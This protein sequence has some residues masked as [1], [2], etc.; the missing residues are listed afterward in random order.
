MGSGAGSS[1]EDGGIGKYLERQ[2]DTIENVKGRIPAWYLLDEAQHLLA[3][4]EQDHQIR[5]D[6]GDVGPEIALE[7]P[8]LNRQWLHRWRLFYRVTWRTVNLRIKCS[9]ETLLRRMLAF[10]SNILRLRWLHKHLGARAE[11]LWLDCDQ[12]PMWFTASANSKTLSPPVRLGVT[13]KENFPATRERF[14]VMTRT[15]YPRLP[16]DGKTIAVMFR[17]GEGDGREIRRKLR[18]PPGVLLQFAPKGSYRLEHTLEYYDW[19][20][21]EHA[22]AADGEPHFVCIADWF[23]PNLDASFRTCVERHGG[24]LVHIPGS[25]TGHVQVNDTRLH[26]PYSAYYIRAETLEAQEQLRASKR[27][28]SVTRQTVLNRAAQCW[29]HVDHAKVSQGFLAAGISIALDGSEDHLLGQ[30]VVEL[31]NTLDMP[32]V[33]ARI[34]VEV[35]G[36]VAAGRLRSLAQCKEVMVPHEEHRAEEE[37]EEARVWQ[38]LEERGAEDEEADSRLDHTTRACWCARARACAHECGTVFVRSVRRPALTRRTMPTL[39]RRSPSLSLCRGRKATGHRR[40]KRSQFSMDRSSATEFRQVLVQWQSLCKGTQPP[41][42]ARCSKQAPFR[43]PWAQ[44]ASTGRV[45]GSK[46]YWSRS[47]ARRRV[48]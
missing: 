26:A 27:L 35:A 14:T 16:A 5:I 22:V 40:W 36:E 24:M 33:R 13:V 41:P 23:K 28:P 4:M 29:S 3:E 48:W 20:L 32:S 19:I 34:G 6:S 45:A 30:E 46:E 15:A 38:A 31:W 7:K 47:C 37:G 25:L 8:V 44:C 42:S 1:E 43:R 12:K 11:L 10:W 21:E 2:V 39:T 18:V 17:V 9:R